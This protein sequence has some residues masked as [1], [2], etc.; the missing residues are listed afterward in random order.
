[1]TRHQ[2]DGEHGSVA[3]TRAGRPASRPPA[4]R[5]REVGVKLNVNGADVEVND[6]SAKSPLWWVL[7]D[8]LACPGRSTAAGPATARRAPC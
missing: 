6:R 4:V 3:M 1:M 7:R 5:A 2:T 8:V